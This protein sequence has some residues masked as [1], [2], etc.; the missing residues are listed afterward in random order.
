MSELDIALEVLGGG[1]TA[2][3][4]LWVFKLKVAL[5]KLETE[6]KTIH[7]WLGNVDKKLDESRSTLDQIAGMLRAEGRHE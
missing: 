3:L 7:N 1:A 6:Q 5:V 4:G 2:A